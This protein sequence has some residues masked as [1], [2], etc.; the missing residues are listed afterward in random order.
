MKRK[1][2]RFEEN[3]S[4]FKLKSADEKDGGGDGS[5]A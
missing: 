5:Q 4:G 2:D 3:L 1:P